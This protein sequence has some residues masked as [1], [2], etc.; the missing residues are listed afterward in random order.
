MTEGVAKFD[1]VGDATVAGLGAEP[2]DLLGA[3]VLHIGEG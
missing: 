3:V 2:F 1:V